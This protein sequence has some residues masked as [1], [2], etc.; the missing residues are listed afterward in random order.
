MKDIKKEINN[1]GDILCPWTERLNIFKMSFLPKL[2]Y[3][4]HEILVKI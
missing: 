4:F 1:W 2:I 3:S